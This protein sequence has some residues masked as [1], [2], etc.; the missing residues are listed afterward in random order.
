MCWV[1]YWTVVQICI[2]LYSEGIANF[3]GKI[4]NAKIALMKVKYD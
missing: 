3:V 2:S 1:L 4:R